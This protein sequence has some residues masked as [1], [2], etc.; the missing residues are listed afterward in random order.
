[1]SGLK[2]LPSKSV[3]IWLI[4]VFVITPP[5]NLN[6]LPANSKKLKQ[7]ANMMAVLVFLFLWAYMFW[8]MIG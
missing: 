7:I 5:S 6:T 8:E 4:A 2:L 1:M 3:P